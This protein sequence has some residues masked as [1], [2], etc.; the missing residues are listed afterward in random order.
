MNPRGLNR[1]RGHAGKRSFHRDPVLP[2]VLLAAGVTLI[3]AVSRLDVTERSK[4]PWAEAGFVVEEESSGDHRATGGV[5]AFVRKVPGE[6]YPRLNRVL[7][8]LRNTPGGAD[9]ADRL[10]E[11][12]HESVVFL[13]VLD[14]VAAPLLASGALPERGSTGVLAG[15]MTRLESFVMDGETFTVTGRLKRSMGGL[16][17]SYLVPAHS[18]LVQHSSESP[19]ASPGWFFAEGIPIT[20]LEGA[21]QT[22][23]EAAEEPE[24]VGGMGRA[25]PEV[26][27]GTFFGLVLVAAG[28][29]VAQ[30]RFLRWLRYHWHGSLSVAF[31]EIAVRPR[32]VMGMHVLLYGLLFGGMAVAVRYPVVSAWVVTLVSGEF[33]SGDLSY[34]GA[35]YMS[36]SVSQAAGATFLHNF[37]VATVLYTVLPSLIIPFAGVVKNALSFAGVGF[38]MAPLWT[39]S[40]ETMVYHAITLTLEMEAYVIMSVVVSALPLR[41]LRGIARNRFFPEW[42]RGL[43]VVASGTV[44]V[45]LMLIA[46]ALYEAATL[47]LLR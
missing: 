34:I 47:I 13:S 9:I 4:E 19:E 12:A 3:A 1:V 8:D 41:M 16:A 30:V 23:E 33:A 2:F 7:G 28:G 17:F 25:R 21:P 42:R 39:G 6:N 32:L 31:T 45:G 46:A 43:A 44:L 24:R 27:W 26:V 38:V 15:D 22:D 5:P 29:A 14:E 10:E 36:G 40:A 35:A 20:L 18:G 37:V 11:C